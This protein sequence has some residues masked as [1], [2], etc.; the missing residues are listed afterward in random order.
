MHIKKDNDKNKLEKDK[1]KTDKTHTNKD[2]KEKSKLIKLTDSQLMDHQAALI[3]KKLILK[4]YRRLK[5][6]FYKTNQTN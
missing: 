1:N 4:N 6:I 3:R 5:V 2:S